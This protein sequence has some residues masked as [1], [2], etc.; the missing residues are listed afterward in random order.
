M[1]PPNP[2]Q[3]TPSSE[4]LIAG[5]YAVDPAHPLPGAGGGL[6]AFAA[7]DRHSGRS[8]LMAVQVRPDAPP[9][10]GALGALSAV[11]R[12]G[13]LLPLAHGPALGPDRRPAWFVICPAPP[14]PAL[15][16]AGVAAPK[17]WNDTELVTRLLRPAAGALAFLAEQNMTYRALRPDNLFVD[18]GAGDALVLG[19]AW[20]GPPALLQPALFEPPYVA[21]CPGPAR[22]EGTVADDVYAL[23][24]LLLALALGRLPL[25]GLDDA[26]IVRRKLELGCFQA[27]T[28]DARLSPQFADLVRGMLAQD[29]RHRPAPDVLADPAGARAR[30]VAA[31]P[32]RRAPRSLEV[33]GIAAWDARTLA[34]AI[35]RAPH[36]GVK[37][38]RL[39]VADHWLR[40]VL[41]DTALASR[42]EEAQAH[43]AAEAA[44]QDA[45]AD[46]R[47]AMRV[48]AMLDPLAPLC[49]DG[50]SV[51][52]DGIGPALADPALAPRLER[53]VACEAVSDWAAARAEHC[54]APAL[55][56]QARHSRAM[57]TQRGW[58]GGLSRLL[59]GL[60]PLLPCRSPVLAGALVTRLADVPHA[61]EAASARP[62]A[63]AQPPIDHELAA[64]IAARQDQ[65]LEGE[66]L[67]L[68]DGDGPGIAML[69][70]LVLLARLQKQSEPGPLP[71]LA[72]WLAG[73]AGPVLDG[74]RSR[75]R[76]LIKQASLTAAIPLGD[77]AALLAILDDAEAH[78]ADNRASDAAQAGIR[79]IDA[80]LAMLAEAGQARAGAARRLGEEIAAALGLAALAATTVA[81]ALR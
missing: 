48:V 15:W 13:V 36:D 79:R 28:A 2:V 32:P 74:W 66:I 67:A 12:P 60:N 47:L 59:Y 10:A 31:R 7:I 80:R 29:P 64:F 42:V 72:G 41:S 46:S 24:V 77:L 22:G 62:E 18:P 57:L 21:M 45:V 78:D 20:A 51:W 54:D 37:L 58:A 63:R 76:R 75:A 53:L 70:Q 34:H 4:P 68:D 9:R 25:A 40:R 38:L 26:T 23:G 30:H 1:A 50:V 35:A 52:P 43:R 5:R 49:W 27:L 56:T 55:R 11:A 6:A 19:C 33:G 17:P 71:G 3:P 61:L 39:G 65:R 44:P 8:G 14:G 16:P 69:P 73:L 81:A